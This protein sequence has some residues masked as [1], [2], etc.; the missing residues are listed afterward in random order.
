MQVKHESSI[1]KKGQR[2]EL[3]GAPNFKV[4]ATEDKPI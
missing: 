2:L 1:R 4:W 3:G